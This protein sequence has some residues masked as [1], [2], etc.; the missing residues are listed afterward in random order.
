METSNKRVVCLYRVSTKGQ[1][2][3]NDIPMQKIACREFI[4]RQGWQLVKEYYEKG[5]SGYKLTFKD[6]D[7]LQKIMTDAKNRLFDVLLV[8]MFDR[9]GRREDETPFVAEWFVNHGIEVWSAQEGQLKVENDTDKLLNYIRFWQSAGESDKTSIRIRTKHEQM[10]RDGQFRGGKPPY[11]YDLERSG[12]FSKRGKELLKLVINKEEAE[13]VRK[14]YDLVYSEGYGCNRIANY[15]NDNNIPTK[16][17]ILWNTSVINYILRNPIYKGYMVFGKNI[18]NDNKYSRQDNSKW[19]LSEKPIEELIIIPVH[20]WDRVQS[21]RSARSYLVSGK[22][23]TNNKKLN[24]V[25]TSKCPLLF[26]GM[27]YCGSCGSPLTT[28]KDYKMWK[29]QDGT[30]NKRR[31]NKYRCS[32]KALSKTYCEGQTTYAQTKIEDTVMD[33]VYNFIDELKKVDLTREINKF[34]ETS[35]EDDVMKLKQLQ[36]EN[37]K[38]YNDLKILKE[39][40]TKSLLGKSSFKPELLASL[41]EEKE[42]AINDTLDKISEVERTINLKKI[43]YEEMIQLQEHIPNWR[44]TF[45]NA[46]IDKKK[47]MLSHIIDNIEVFRDRVKVHFKLMLEQFIASS[48]VA[49]GILNQTNGESA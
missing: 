29:N 3:R 20:I 32:G 14:I 36:S 9:L 27:I 8:F 7:E 1:V 40:V 37:E 18:F 41:I 22:K 39:E 35:F 16:T 25:K 46:T 43:E 26:V 21:I 17:G 33:E 4:D 23:P 42:K 15:L 24:I 19:I 30:I 48:N 2:D 6:R 10:V 38:N 5:V 13:V 49:M 28:T 31:R 47:M 34:R 45:E 12:Q 44:R 11:G